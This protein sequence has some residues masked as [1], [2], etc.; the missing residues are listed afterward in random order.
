MRSVALLVLCDLGPAGV[1]KVALSGIHRSPLPDP[2]GT[3]G[4]RAAVKKTIKYSRFDA[5]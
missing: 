5:N 3:A 2:F 1:R 4:H